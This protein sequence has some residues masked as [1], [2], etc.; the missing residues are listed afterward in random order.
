MAG[1]YFLLI[2]V[3]AY[4]WGQQGYMNW[5]LISISVSLPRIRV[6]RVRA[7]KKRRLEMEAQQESEVGSAREMPVPAIV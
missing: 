1:F 3:A 2:S 5:I 4:S 7:A 6:L